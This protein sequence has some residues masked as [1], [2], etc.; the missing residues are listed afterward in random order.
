MTTDRPLSMGR[1]LA[2]FLPA[3]TLWAAPGSVSAADTDAERCEHSLSTPVNG[4][5]PLCIRA[6]SSVY[7]QGR[8]AEL[9]RNH[10]PAGEFTD[11]I[12]N[13][14]SHTSAI[15]RIKVDKVTA[16]GTW[17]QGPFKPTFWLTRD[18]DIEVLCNVSNLANGWQSGSCGRRRFPSIFQPGRFGLDSFA[19][20]LTGADSA[21]YSFRY[22]CSNA[23]A[24]GT[25]TVRT[26]ERGSLCGLGNARIKSLKAWV[27]KDLVDEEYL[28]VKFG[29][30]FQETPLVFAALQTTNG[31]DTAQTRIRNVTPTGFDVKVEEEASKDSEIGHVGERVRHYAIEPGPIHDAGGTRIGEAGFVDVDQPNRDTWHTLELDHQY[32]GHLVVIM[33]LNSENGPQPATVRLRNVEGDRFE[34]KIEEWMYLDDGRH[35]TERLVYMAVEQGSYLFA[36]GSRLQAQRHLFNHEWRSVEFLDVFAKGPI[37]FSQAQTPFGAD[38]IVTRQKDV[39]ALGV[40][41]R[42]QEEEAREKLGPYHLR[43]EVGIIAVQSPVRFNY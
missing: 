21:W 29:T 10:A 13:S 41:I 7:R 26:G 36:D 2:I 22:E 42:L 15:E 25:T 4:L 43:E 18:L 14:R 31:G 34:F 40:T 17:W 5:A 33:M 35:T 24:R 37:V 9:Q 20:R 32:D 19:L 3:L 30:A 11:Y 1:L 23:G 8:Y 16:S 6:T 38:P 28:P 12:E 39:S 27:V